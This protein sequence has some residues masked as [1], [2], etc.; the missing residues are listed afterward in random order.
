M[1]SSNEVIKGLQ[2]LSKYSESNGDDPNDIGAAHDVIFGPSIFKKE[3]ADKDI[4]ELFQLGW[5]YGGEYDFWY[6]YV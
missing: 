3:V 2:I 4:R 6:K 5:H 1:A